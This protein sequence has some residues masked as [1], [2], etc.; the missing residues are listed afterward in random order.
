MAS[1]LIHADNLALVSEFVVVV[2]L[3]EWWIFYR[4]VA[5]ADHCGHIPDLVPSLMEGVLPFPTASI[6][7]IL[8]LPLF[9]FIR[10]SEMAGLGLA[11]LINAH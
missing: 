4:V 10:H 2:I 1:I 8:Q 11:A 7:L 9:P 5:G 3:S 6:I